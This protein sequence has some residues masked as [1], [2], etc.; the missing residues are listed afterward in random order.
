ACGWKGGDGGAAAGAEEAVR[1]ALVILSA[2]AAPAGMLPVVLGAGWAG[3]LLLEAVGHGLE[4][5][6]HRR[7]TSG[8]SG[9]MGELVAS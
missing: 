7:G 5:D 6:F 1:L 8:F 4:G 3:V 9:H 2:A